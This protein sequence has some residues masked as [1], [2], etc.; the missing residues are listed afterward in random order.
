[1]NPTFCVHTRCRS[2]NRYEC[3]HD[4]TIWEHIKQMFCEIS[5]MISSVSIGIHIL[6]YSNRDNPNRHLSGVNP[7]Y[8]LSINRFTYSLTLTRKQKL[9]A[10]RRPLSIKSI[11]TLISNVMS[12]WPRGACICALAE[13]TTKGICRGL[14]PIWRTN[15]FIFTCC[16]VDA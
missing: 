1:M 5:K 9:A 8:I 3:L 15:H 4:L 6:K 16:Q 11:V 10:P 7:G 12:V 2:R 13:L 14:S